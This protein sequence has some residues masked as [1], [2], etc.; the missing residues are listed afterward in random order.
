[1]TVESPGFHARDGWFFRRE[2]GGSVRIMAPDSLGPGAHQVVKLDPSTWAS[3][4]AL[5]SAAGE[6]G[7]TYR[8][9][10]AFHQEG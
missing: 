7:D 9:A 2:D 3:V 5:V 1:M 10:L 8:Q 6:S 4:V